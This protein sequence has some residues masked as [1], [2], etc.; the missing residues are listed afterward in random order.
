MEYKVQSKGSSDFM[1]AGK[2]LGDAIEKNFARIAQD[3]EIGNVAG[4]KLER[5]HAEYKADILGSAGGV[6]L[7]IT[8]KG[9]DGF[10][11]GT[12]DHAEDYKVWIYAGKDDIPEPIEA[13]IEPTERFDPFVDREWI[14]SP[15]FSF[16]VVW[17]L[18]DIV[19]GED[20]ISLYTKYMSKYPTMYY[21]QPMLFTAQMQKDLQRKRIPQTPKTVSILA[22]ID[23]ILSRFSETK[24]P[25][26]AQSI[27]YY[28]T[29]AYFD[30]P[31]NE[32][33]TC[34]LIALRKKCGK[35]QKQVAEDAGIALREYQRFESGERNFNNAS[36]VRGVALATAL[37]TTE[38]NLIV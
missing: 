5:V 17:G 21:L 31:V 34:R 10:V 25:N 13:N 15:D 32:R 18:M 4:Y 7:I 36:F 30:R 1:I 22:R 19:Y 6:E 37:E 3:A 8:A 2:N 12:Y 35:T 20:E 26:N 29:R 24:I 23:E 11:G 9:S 16:G 14:E 33:C 38:K 27:G 28:K